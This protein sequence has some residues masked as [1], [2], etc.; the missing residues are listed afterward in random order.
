MKILEY[1]QVTPFQN[2]SNLHDSTCSLSVG[3]FN[4]IIDIS[5]IYLTWLICLDGQ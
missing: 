5:M 4:A 3:Q 2:N 1:C